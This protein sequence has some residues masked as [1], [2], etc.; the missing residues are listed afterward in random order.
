M[1]EA[2]LSELSTATTELMESLDD[3]AAC[4]GSCKK[5]GNLAKGQ[6]RRKQISNLLSLCNSSLSE[7]KG[8]C[9]K[10]SMA[11]LRL[12]KKSDKPSSNWG[13]ATSGNT[14]GEKSKLDSARNR[15]QIQGQMGEGAAETET[16]HM[17][18]GRQTASRS[19]RE[20]YQKYRR[21]TEAA[22]NS[23]PIPLGQRETIRRYFELIRPQESDQ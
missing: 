13:M 15:E 20:Q 21:M 6:G 7:C 16:T 11:K 4:Q 5:L 9:N 2:G 3:A 12:R 23:E 10:N 14:D 19:Y 1:E 22:L 8:N 17:P 18:E